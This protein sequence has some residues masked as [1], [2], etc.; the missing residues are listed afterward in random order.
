MTLYLRLFRV[1]LLAYFGRRLSSWATSKVTFHVHPMDLDVYG[2]MN[3][4]RY[5]ALMDIGRMDL[6]IRAKLLPQLKKEGW[7]V[8]VASQT[9]TYKRELKLGQRFRL[10]TRL[11]GVDDRYMYLVQEFWTG[12]KIAARAV[13]KGRMVD[14]GKVSGTRGLIDPD[15]FLSHLGT[16]P[17]DQELPA[18]VT[19]WAEKSRIPSGM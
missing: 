8:V 3:N 13:V 16:P 11:L 7:F 2:H 19:D 14:S 6:M 4:A 9:I 10:H 1:M 15:Q 12:Q 18:W 5:L 17:A